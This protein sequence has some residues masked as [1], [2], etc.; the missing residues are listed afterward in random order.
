MFGSY[1]KSMTTCSVMHSWPQS[2]IIS[3]PSPSLPHH[4][5][6]F[7]VSVLQTRQSVS[8]LRAAAANA[9]STLNPFLLLPAI[10]KYFCR[11]LV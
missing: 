7:T 3:C 8:Q 2:N 10:S 4:P 1:L 11:N 5:P 6:G 9:S